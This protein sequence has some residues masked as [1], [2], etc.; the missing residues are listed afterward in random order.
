M[1]RDILIKALTSYEIQLMDAEMNG[2]KEQI[3]FLKKQINEAH[4]ALANEVEYSN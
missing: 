3:Q 2:D 1:N 4:K